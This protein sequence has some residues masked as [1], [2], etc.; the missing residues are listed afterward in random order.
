MEEGIDVLVVVALKG[1]QYL[2]DGYF[3]NVDAFLYFEPGPVGRFKVGLNL[4][5]PIPHLY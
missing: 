3:N 1:L 2:I 4:V 5:G